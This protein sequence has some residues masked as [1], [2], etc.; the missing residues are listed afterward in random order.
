MYVL[1][2]EPSEPLLLQPAFW[3]LG[4]MP[5][6]GS[7]LGWGV[8]RQRLFAWHQYNE[9]SARQRHRAKVAQ[10]REILLRAILDNAADAILLLDHD[11]EI[12][13]CNQVALDIF[14]FSRDALVGRNIEI[15]LPSHDHLAPKDGIQRL[16]AAGEALGVEWQLRGRHAE[17]TTF[18]I[19]LVRTHMPEIPGTV[20]VIRE[21]TTRLDLEAQRIRDAL[22]AERH[23]IQQIAKRRGQILRSIG[24]GLHAEVG[25]LIQCTSDLE[26]KEAESVLDIAHDLLPIVNRLQNLSMVD[27]SQSELQLD[28]VAVSGLVEELTAAIGP[29]I[30]R[31]RT[32]LVVRLDQDVGILKTDRQKLSH[33]VRNLMHNASHHTQE[34]TVTLEVEREPGRGSDWIAFH[35]TDT[36]SGMTQEE[37]DAVFKVFRQFNPAN[38]RDY[39]EQ[40]LGLAL[41]QHCA[42]LLG[43][44]I[45]VRSAPGAGSTF[46]LRI[47]IGA[48]RAGAHGRSTSMESDPGFN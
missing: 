31:N 40:G 25:T 34:G 29:V 3:L 28:R 10:S 27:D 36:G 48:H 44:H 42:Q 41:S 9:M 30:E 39:L 11:E 1:L 37:V 2:P 6:I 23:E 43:G 45:A 5:V 21:A 46:S 24:R 13:D 26:S 20:Y 35:V 22:N 15:I 12:Q 8:Y 19:D 18:P 17:G 33:A 32:Q 14:G 16:T 38:S 47:P 7:A 4:A